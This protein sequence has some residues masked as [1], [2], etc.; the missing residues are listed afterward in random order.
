MWF[1]FLSSTLCC[2]RL[3]PSFH[4]VCVLLWSSGQCRPCESCGDTAESSASPRWRIHISRCYTC[5]STGRGGVSIRG[6]G[7]G[8]PFKTVQLTQGFQRRRRSGIF[9]W[10][11]L[12]FPAQ[13]AFWPR[14]HLVAPQTAAGPERADMP[15]RCLLTS[16]PRMS[17]GYVWDQRG[18][19]SNLIVIFQRVQQ[20]EEEPARASYLC[21]IWAN[22]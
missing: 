20:V 12:Q 5:G 8:V 13:S 4:R 11:I 17:K 14:L 19:C 2:A 18:S 22:I 9:W 16:A 3:S 10:E 1:I 7:S 6:I 21:I 15:L